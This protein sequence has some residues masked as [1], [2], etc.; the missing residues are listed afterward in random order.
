VAFLHRNNNVFAWS[1]KDMPWIDPSVIVHRM[2]VYP[3]HRLV[4]E[5]RRSFAL[6]RNQAI[7]EEVKKL[8]Q[9]RF[10]K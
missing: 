3:S 6:E 7:A 8:L 4:K 5:R 9:A 10:I 1:H 2:N